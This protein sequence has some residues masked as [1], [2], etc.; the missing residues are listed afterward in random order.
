MKNLLLLSLVSVVFLLTGCTVYVTVNGLTVIGP[1][2]PVTPVNSP[3]PENTTQVSTQ[4]PTSPIPATTAAH[5]PTFTPTHTSTPVPPTYTPTS[6]PTNTRTPTPTS[7]HTPVPTS[8]PTPLPTS[9]P[10]LVC[11]ATVKTTL[12]LNIRS[13][14][15]TTKPVLAKAQPNSRWQVYEV[16][17]V[18]VS[19]SRTDEWVRIELA[20]GRAA[21]M[22][23]YYN[24][25]T[26]VEYD[27]TPDCLLLRYG[28]GVNDPTPTPV[29]TATPTPTFPPVTQGPNFT[30]TQ[31]S[32]PVPVTP[33]TGEGK[34]TI[35]VTASTLNGRASASL[36][37]AVVTRFD[38]DTRLN[39]KQFIPNGT[40]G[41][42]AQVNNA[43]VYMG[44]AA[45]LYARFDYD[46]SEACQDV[47]G[48]QNWMWDIYYPKTAIGWH[49]TI[50]DIDYN[51]LTA[52]LNVLVMKGYRPAIKAVE[53]T[54][55]VDEA[56]SRGGI[57]IWRTTRAPDCPSMDQE[58][59]LAAWLQFLAYS[60]YLDTRFS[61]VEPSNECPQYFGN[62]AWTDAFY[63][64]LIRIFG[65][66]GYRVV[67]GTQPPGWWEKYQVQ[68]LT[69]TWA[70]A[71]E[72]GSCFGYHA[73]GVQKG[74]RV[75]DSDI[76][77]GYRHR[78]IH[79]WLS[80]IGYDDIPF[81]VTE[82]GTGDGRDPFDPTDFRDWLKEVSRDQYII[83]VAWW[84]AGQWGGM[85]ANGRMVEAARLL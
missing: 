76:W 54:R 79:D 39:V 37:A 80:E 70:A 17:Y 28:P 75:A 32:G 6:T 27:A 14:P 19:D 77:I 24:N 66:R 11:L 69:Q 59:Q 45:E 7:T 38:R 47:V 52:S 5:S 44:T 30:P 68:A 78:Q 43:Y 20:D 22:A 72:Y 10:Q 21:W 57:G 62:L 58:P 49:V 60:P 23:A 65:E 1:E 4:V 81:C 2:P 29:S 56:L 64:E 41:T 51:D 8:T 34:C 3:I 15:D 50:P 73:Y 42:W 36:A 9:A 84:T 31:E 63:S 48:Y 67:I 55:S 40:V 33:G 26:W 13:S 46:L 16:L 25:E 35:V 71:R 18:D 83:F 12:A 82:V 53:D 85:T 61:Y 74:K